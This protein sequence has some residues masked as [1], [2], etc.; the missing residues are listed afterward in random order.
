MLYDVVL[1][2]IV[3]C[4]HI[5]FDS[6]QNFLRDFLHEDRLKNNVKCIFLDKYVYILLIYNSL[7]INK[8]M[9]LIIL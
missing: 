5:T 2:H 4:G 7:T 6:V 1:R 9:I 8:E 3:I